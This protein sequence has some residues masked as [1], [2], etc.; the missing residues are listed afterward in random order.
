[1]FIMNYLA[2]AFIV[3]AVVL[4]CGAFG[5]V[6]QTGVFDALLVVGERSKPQNR[7][8]LER[9]MRPMSEQEYRSK[10]Q[11]GWSTGCAVGFVLGLLLVVKLSS[12]INKSA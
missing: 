4:A 6:Y 10:T 5:Y 9:G 11:Y 7:Q 8:L 2:K 12:D 3:V 1:M